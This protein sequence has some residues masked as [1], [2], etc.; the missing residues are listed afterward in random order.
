MEGYI[1]EGPTKGGYAYSENIGLGS[2]LTEHGWPK[3]ARFKLC[4]ISDKLLIAFESVWHIGDGAS[5]CVA[6][7][8]YVGV[9]CAKGADAL[10]LDGGDDRALSGSTVWH[11]K[12]KGE[13]DATLL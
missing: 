13:A 5:V 10:D 12:G 7:S 3:T 11:G 2:T 8:Q 6:E 1:L 4:T 9:T